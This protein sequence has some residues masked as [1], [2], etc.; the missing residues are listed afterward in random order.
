MYRR[1][2]IVLIMVKHIMVGNEK[3]MSLIQ[4]STVYTQNNAEAFIS[5]QSIKGRALIWVRALI[6]IE[7]ATWISGSVRRS[8]SSLQENGSL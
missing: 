8:N 4:V 6:F 7:L 2:L 3:G 5:F 1:L